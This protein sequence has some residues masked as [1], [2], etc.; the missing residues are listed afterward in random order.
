[1]ICAMSL[2]IDPCAMIRHSHLVSSRVSIL[3]YCG[4]C[5]S[6]AA[7]PMRR[8]TA[9][10]RHYCGPPL[11]NRR[12][13]CAGRTNR[14]EQRSPFSRSSPAVRMRRLQ[15][16][17]PR[18]ADHAGRAR[19]CPACG[20]RREF[21]LETDTK[22]FMVVPGPKRPVLSRR[23]HGQEVGYPAAPDPTLTR[24]RPWPTYPRRSRRT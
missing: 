11:T 7:W 12:P 9:H 14:M 4:D 19:L 16:T 13:G 17:E 8:G 1:M 2:R 6:G 21:Q 24:R 20:R 3:K 22:Y 5:P 18:T 15:T 10:D 23:H